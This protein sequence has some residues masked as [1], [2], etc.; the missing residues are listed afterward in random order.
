MKLLQH[1]FSH[2]SNVHHHYYTK[3]IPPLSHLFNPM[4]ILHII[5]LLLLPAITSFSSSS[6]FHVIYFFLLIF[7]TAWSKKKIPILFTACFHFQQLFHVS[8]VSC[9]K[10]RLFFVVEIWEWRKNVVIII[11]IFVLLRKLDGK[12]CWEIIWT[13]FIGIRETK[14]IFFFQILIWCITNY[15]II[16]YFSISW[17]IQNS[18]TEIVN[19]A[20]KKLRKLSEKTI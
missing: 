3:T 13:A 19:I 4:Y 11:M 20:K 7:F 8:H 16:F 10:K 12:W 2:T 9:K 15:F 14:R 18:G 17:S 6:L 5:F 1:L